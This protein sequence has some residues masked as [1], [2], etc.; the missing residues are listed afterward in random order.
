MRDGGRGNGQ[1]SVCARWVAES[2]GGAHPAISPGG[3]RGYQYLWWTVAGTPAYMADG[4]G[5]Q[6]LYIDPETRTVIVKFSHVPIGNRQAFHSGMDLMASA[7]H[8]PTAG[9]AIHQHD[10]G[11]SFGAGPQETDV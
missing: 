7:S 11:D 10:A 2:T 6:Y 1:Q 4:M 5:G 9:S 8:W 3:K